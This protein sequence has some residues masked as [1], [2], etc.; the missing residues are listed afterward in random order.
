MRN[1]K[2]QIIA[3]QALFL[4]LLCI[5]VFTPFGFIPLGPI[6]ATIV[7]IP[8]IFMGITLGK[9]QGSI[10]G[11]MMGCASLISNTFSP[12]LISFAFSPF[13]TIGNIHG[14]IFSLIICFIP[15]II[16]GLLA[17]IIGENINDKNKASI[18]AL[19]DSLIHSILV[20][21]MIV[22]FFKQEYSLA[23]GISIN[24]VIK[25]IAITFLTQS[26]IEALLAALFIYLIYPYSLKLKQNIK[27]IK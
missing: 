18:L 9:K 3:I 24:L 7:H 6:K 17:G 19:L 23:T 10:S 26:S 2:T 21:A 4:A 5:L 15:R 1:K 14:G 12:G 20:L 8:V 11:F 27:G 25:T 16:L 22:I 13:I